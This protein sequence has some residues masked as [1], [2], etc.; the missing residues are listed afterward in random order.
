MISN[1]IVYLINE[2]FDSP[3]EARLTNET[4]NGKTIAEGIMQTADEKNRNGRYYAKE[5][6]FP[7]LTAPRTIELLDAGYSRAE[8]AHPLDKDLQ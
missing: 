5:D 6:L 3:A 1:K 7:Q 2:G 4:L 8:M